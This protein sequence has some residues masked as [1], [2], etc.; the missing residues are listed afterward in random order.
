[1]TVAPGSVPSAMPWPRTQF[2]APSYQTVPPETTP[3]PMRVSTVHSMA[4]LM[5][6]LGEKEKASV[7]VMRPRL[8]T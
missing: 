3:P 1:M 2:M 4:R 6:P 7:P 5:V 8:L